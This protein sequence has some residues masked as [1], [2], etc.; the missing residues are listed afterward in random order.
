MQMVPRRGK[1]K[2]ASRGGRCFAIVSALSLSPL[3]TIAVGSASA[4][5]KPLTLQPRS[6]D[7]LPDLTPDQ[8]ERFELGKIEFSRTL[9]SSDGLGPVFNDHS[10]ISCHNAGG[11]G[12][13]G[14]LRIT[15]FGFWDPDSGKFDPLESLGGTLIQDNVADGLDPELCADW[16]PATLP[17]DDNPANHTANRVTNSAFGIGLVEALDDDDILANAGAYGGEVHWVPVIEDPKS[18]LR[19]GRMGWKAQLATVHSFTVD[20]SLNEMGLTSVHL[21]DPVP[22][23]G[24][25]S[26]LEFCDILGP[27]HPQDPVDDQGVTFT[28]RVTDFQRF[29]APPP[30]TPRSGMTGEQIFMEVGCG[31]CHIPS[32]TT[33]DSE[34]IEDALSGRQFRPYSDFLLHNMGLASD[35]IPQGDATE[36]QIRTPSLWGLRHRDALMHDG[37]I[38]GGSLADRILGTGPIPEGVID[39]HRYPL[40]SQTAIDSADDFF[41]RSETDQMLVIAFL[42]SLGRAEFDFT[43]NNIVGNSD[44][45]EFV[46]CYTGP[47]GSYVEPG[48]NPMDDY[49]AIGDINQDGAIDETDFEMFL[50]AYDGDLEPCTLW[51]Q[52][53][54]A[55]GP[56]IEVNVPEK[57]LCTGDLN[58]DGVVNVADLLIVFDAWG[59]CTDPDNCPADLNGDGLVNVQD[60]LILFDHWGKCS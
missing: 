35:F 36:W 3:L 16:D 60:L 39:R 32:W 4:E 19:V 31:Q 20:A 56:E 38:E 26:L 5:D 46:A 51:L 50:L 10:C 42:D 58:N 29:L 22:P 43:G 14:T 59:E 9:S 33:M 57:C 21:P 34:D 11:A 24:D 7:P 40:A 23:R 48:E 49:C 41:E 55:V 30:Q 47:E 25:H 17:N 53:A 54:D 6:G 52:L 1:E 18:P 45:N 27:P 44:F 28:Q 12:G 2:P 37:S 15:R 13:S 8:L